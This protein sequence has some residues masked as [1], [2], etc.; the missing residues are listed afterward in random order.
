MLM[1]FTGLES[2]I[3]DICLGNFG[4]LIDIDAKLAHD[5]VLGQVGLLPTAEF[6]AIGFSDDE[7]EAHAEYDT[8]RDL[9]SDDPFTI[10]KTACHSAAVAFRLRYE[11]DSAMGKTFMN[12]VSAESVRKPSK[13]MA[14]PAPVTT[15]VV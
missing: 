6:D 7:L 3:G 11:K 15:P 8:H 9:T 4:M 13:S 1:R 12:S 10:K 5:A 2:H 14:E